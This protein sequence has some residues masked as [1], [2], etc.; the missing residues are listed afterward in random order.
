MKPIV[1]IPSRFAA[2][3]LPGKPL[4]PIHGQ[5]M[6]VHVWRRAIEADLG[7][8]VVAT[9]HAGI[10]AAIAAA[11]GTAVMTR[12]DHPS[13]TDR[14]AEALAIADPGGRHDVVVNFQGD[15][16]TIAPHVLR[17][18]A[19][20]LDDGAVA[21]GTPVALMRGADEGAAPSVVKMV[22]SPIGPQR[23]RALYFSRACVPWG[24]GPL[25]HH[26]GLYV[27]RRSALQAF[28]ALAP[29][30]LEQREKLE[31]LR[32]LEAGMR[33]DAALVDDVPLGVDT[34]EDL[35]RARSMLG[36]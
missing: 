32:A 19:A 6:I 11:G 22:G 13:G 9:D 8:V 31:Q 30:L 28:V 25:Y 5:P 10:A 16:P 2:S 3:R 20:L 27:W 1:L 34:P 17:E 35:E 29:S 26:I 12:P 23:F 7:P 24:D 15:L 4:A 21:I 33:I 18:T 36:H 14:I